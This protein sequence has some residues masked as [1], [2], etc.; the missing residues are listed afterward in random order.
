MPDGYY[1]EYVTTAVLYMKSVGYHVSRRLILSSLKYHF[2]MIQFLYKI[3]EDSKYIIFEKS[4]MH[5]EINTYL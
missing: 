4:E 5:R 1:G 2:V 3:K